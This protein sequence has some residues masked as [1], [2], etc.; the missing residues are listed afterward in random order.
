MMS[1]GLMPYF[2]VSSWKLR[3]ATLTLASVVM[4]WPF[5]S[6]QPTTSAAPNSLASGVTCW[7][8][9][10][11]SSRLTLLRMTLPWQ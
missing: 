1:S 10:S 8:R 7:N 4:A 6:M 3:S 11:P 2:S 5:S 9:F